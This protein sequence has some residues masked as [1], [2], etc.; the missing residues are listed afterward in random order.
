MPIDKKKMSSMKKTYGAKKGEQVYYAME[1][2]EKHDEHRS[3]MS[4]DD[5]ARKLKGK[6]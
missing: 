5:V 2:K 3:K 4:M 6:R 1:N